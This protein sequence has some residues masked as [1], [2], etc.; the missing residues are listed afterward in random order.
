MVEQI[1]QN[2]IALVAGQP[3]R[4]HFKNHAVV[5]KRIK[6]PLTSLE[7]EVQSLV[8]EVDEEDGVKVVKTFST[9]AQ[10]LAAL[11]APYLPSRTY[12]NYDFVITKRGQDFVTEYTVDVLPH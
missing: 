5:P 12:L 9:L 4:L 10:K 2:Y 6:D 1:L 11:L 3:K 8:F 7:K